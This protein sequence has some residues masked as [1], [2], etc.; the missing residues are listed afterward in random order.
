M[1]AIFRISVKHM[2]RKKISAEIAARVL[3]ACRRRCALCFGLEGRAGVRNGQIAH[4]DRD[5]QNNKFENLVWLCLRHHEY[6]DRQPLQSRQV[7]E[8]ELIAHRS[9]LWEY[10]KALPMAWVDADRKPRRQAPQRVLSLDVYDRKVG[11][12]RA[13]YELI[14]IAVQN[15]TVEL[16]ELFAF[17]AATDEA[18]F[19]FGKDVED[20]LQNLQEKALLLRLTH[21][22][23]SHPSFGTRPN[24]DRPKTI[25]DNADLLVWFSEQPAVLRQLFSRYIRL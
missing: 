8:R 18:L 15:A 24:E 19:M 4:V 9:E 14:R 22:H 16:P 11:I 2:A 20:Y 21:L 17:Y 13:V 1:A 23:M 10:L 3:I 25:K 7:D 5:N 6:Y 12:Y